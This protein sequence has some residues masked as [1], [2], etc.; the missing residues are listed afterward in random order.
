M[1]F[2][3]KMQGFSKNFLPVSKIDKLLVFSGGVWYDVE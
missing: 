2:S 3:E 1:Q